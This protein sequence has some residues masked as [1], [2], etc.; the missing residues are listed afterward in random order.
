VGE[1]VRVS[2]KASLHNTANIHLGNHVRIDDFCVLSAGKG[3]IHIGNYVHIAVYSSLMGQGKIQLGNFSGLSSRVSIYSS[4]DDYSG[5]AMTNPTVPE[6]LTHV[7]HGDVVLGEHV[8][9][10]AGA[11]ILPDVVLSEGVAIGALTLIRKSCPA[12]GIYSGSPAKRIGER[13]RKLLAL[14]LQ[15]G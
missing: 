8:I 2:R 12:F 3:G 11:I 5:N 6:H 4:N 14:A 13:S 9:V 10:G 15:L 1:N 7:K